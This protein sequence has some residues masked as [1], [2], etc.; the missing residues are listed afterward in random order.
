MFAINAKIYRVSII[1]PALSLS[2]KQLVVGQRK[3]NLQISRIFIGHH[4]VVWFLFA[5]IS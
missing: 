5:S 4:T 1:N 3:K 2:M